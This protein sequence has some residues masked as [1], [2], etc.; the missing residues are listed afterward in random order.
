MKL[1]KATV[2]KCLSVIIICPLP[3]VQTENVLSPCNSKTSSPLEILST[4]FIGFSLHRVS[5]S[6]LLFPHT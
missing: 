3:Q 6:V 4:P 2:E 5:T 1:L